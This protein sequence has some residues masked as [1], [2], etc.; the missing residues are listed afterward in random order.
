MNRI[1]VAASLLLA[2]S[3][4]GA[5]R[6]DDAVAPLARALH[7]RLIVLDTHL[8]TPANLARPGWSIM[9]RHDREN[10]L[11][12]VDY[13]RMVDGGLDG[14]FWAIFTPQGPQTSEAFA[15]A[16]NAALMRAVQIREMVARNNDHFALAETAADA[17][18]IARAGKRIVFQSIE[19]SY[20]LG[21]DLTLL[22]TFYNLGVRLV[23][24]VHLSNN[25][26]ADSSTDPS[27]PRWNGLSP[28]GVQLVAQA[29]RLG[30]VIDASHASD[31]VFDQ[32]LTLS[33]TPI[34]LSHSGCRNVFDHPRNIGD[35][36]LRR[37]AATGGVIQIDAVGVFLAPMQNAAERKRALDAIDASFGPIETLNPAQAAARAKARRAVD[38]RFPASRATFDDFIDQLL[39][40]LSVVGPDHVGIGADWDGGGGVAGFDDVVDLPKVTA[41]LVQ[42]GYTSAE[43]AKIMGGNVLRLLQQAEDHA[44]R[45]KAM[46]RR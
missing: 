44:K 27:G 11:S 16:R 2:S 30:M 32:L 28:L 46:V 4:A 8:D 15:A 3:A 35:A 17:D 23:G 5:A 41:R 45:Q 34:L 40:A 37:L 7:E 21:H 39:H 10:D 26:F 14:G 13:P 36:R 33:K 9:D 25:Q 31:A 22:E 18:R 19:N 1:G 29:N 38:A 43:I 12:Q 20:P 6:A 24:P 42:E